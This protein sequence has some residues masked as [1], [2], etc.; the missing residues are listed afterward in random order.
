MR[1][2]PARALESLLVRCYDQPGHLL[3]DADIVMYRAKTLGKAR[4]A[5]FDTTMHHRAEP[6]SWRP[7]CG[8]PRGEF[9]PLPA[10]CV[11]NNWQNYR[12]RGTGT[13]ASPLVALFPSEFIP[14]A[15]ETGMIILLVSG[16]LKHA[17]RC[18]HG[19]HD[20]HNTTLDDQRESFR[21]QLTQ[22]D[23]I[24]QIN[25]VLLHTGWTHTV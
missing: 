6:C 9:Q 23:L 15:E 11:T 1:C 17:G 22:P 14:V 24:K 10:D 8:V 16:Y 21:K 18:T 7:I 13:L 12:F 4:Y 5:V 3:R 20:S 2:L 19:T 25:Q